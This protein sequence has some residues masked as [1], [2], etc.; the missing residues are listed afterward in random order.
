VEDDCV[1]ANV[2]FFTVVVTFLV[3]LYGAGAAAYGSL[4]R[5]PDLGFAGTWSAQGSHV[6]ASLLDVVPELYPF[7]YGAVPT[8]ALIRTLPGHALTTENQVKNLMYRICRLA[9]LPER[10]W[11]C[12]VYDE[13]NNSATDQNGHH[14]LNYRRFFA[15]AQD[16]RVR[17]VFEV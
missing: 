8:R 12:L 14:S 4:R 17:G 5:R 1:L 15:D 2:G 7:T 10:G 11:H 13:L 3:A 6:Q 16:G 9:G